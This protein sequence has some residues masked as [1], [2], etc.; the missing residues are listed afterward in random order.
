MQCA[1]TITTPENYF[2]T[3]LYTGTGSAQSITG[4]GFQPDLAWIKSRSHSTS[5]ELHDSVRGEPSR[6]SSDSSSAAATSLNG[7]VS[8]A[9]DGFT[10]DG[11]GGGGE[12]NTNSRTYVAWLWKAASSNVTNN[13][14]TLTSTVSASPESGFSIVR[15]TGT[16]S[17]S[18]TVGHGLTKA[19][20]LII[21]KGLSHTVD[22]YVLINIDGT[23]A[24]DWAKLN[25]NQ[26][27]APDSP[28]RFSANSKTINN[29]GWNGYDMINYCFHDAP[30]YQRIG[31][32]I[33]NGSAN[34]PFIYTGFEPAWIMIKRTDAAGAW[35]IFDNKRNSA[36]PRNSILQADVS[37]LEYTNTNY[38]TNFYANGFQFLNS[39]ADWNASG[40]NYIF[41]AIAANP[42]TSA[43]SKA[44]SFQTKLYTGTGNS[45][46]QITGLS[47]KPDFTWIKVRNSSS[48]NHLLIDS[49]RG[50]ASDGDAKIVS[51]N[52]TEVEFERASISSFNSNGFT[53]GNYGGSNE[54]SSYNYVS[55]NWKALD[56]DRNLASINN[57]GESSTIVSVNNEAGFGIAKGYV[58]SN[59]YTATLGHGFNTKPEL[60]IYKPTSM[61]AHW[62]AYSEHGGPLL[63]SNNV[64]K[65]SAQ[66]AATSDSLFNITNKTFVAG[67]TASAHSFIAYCWRSISGYSKIGTYTISSASD[68]VI[69]G[70]GFTPS[71]VMVKR[72]DSTGSWVITDASRLITKELY[73][74][75]NNTENTD[76]NGVQSFDSDGFTVGT[77][78]WL[79]ASGG[80]YLYMA[81]K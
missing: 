74:D 11:T 10:V 42:D 63:G 79:G 69:T 38:N 14:G 47:F 54:S 55:W 71:W 34:G 40:G 76:S 3:K 77:G 2:Q 30:G 52:S 67:A 44:N 21:Q 31:S 35:N 23:G 68:R 49:V 20:Q 18:D 62:Y 1:N 29:W 27:Y 78:S 46:L 41:L 48:W 5:H 56:H 16:A 32:Y 80:T 6:I 58:A 59:G 43:P 12:V 26:A 72:T 4:V 15:Y 39:T 19:P 9:S 36:N 17:Y 28:T 13:D 66:T 22:W 81:F 8:L 25:T 53:L 45:G 70:L 61:S 33:G 73:A 60:I 64:L 24:W 65:L 50:F 75:L 57:D 7:F 37:D 51:S